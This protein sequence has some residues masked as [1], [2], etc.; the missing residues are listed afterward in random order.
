[1]ACA[2]RENRCRVLRADDAEHDEGNRLRCQGFHLKPIQTPRLFQMKPISRFG[3]LSIFVSMSLPLTAETWIGGTSVNWSDAANWNPGLPASGANIIISD[4][5]AN[6]GITLN[7]ASHTVGSVTFGTTGTRL[8]AFPIVTTAATT[9]TISGGVIANAQFT[10]ISPRFRG[11]VLLSANQNWQV[12]GDP[13]SHAADSGVAFNEIGA[14][15]GGTLGLNGTLTKTGPG[16]LTIGPVITTGPGDIIVNE[17]SLKLNAGGSL[18]HIMENAEGGGKVVV[19]NS[20][21]LIISKNSGTF[22]ISRPFQFNGT[23]N[24][25][26]GSG[27]NGLTGTFDVGSDIAWNGTHTITNNQNANNANNVNY[28]FTGAM[29]GTGSITKSG[30]SQLIL[31]GATANTISGPV[32]VTGGE[33]NLDKTDVQAVGGNI[34]LTGGNLRINKPNQ[35]AD[36]ASIT[37]NG[38]LINFTADRLETIAALTINSAATS[39]L[40]GLTV[41]GATTITAGTQELNSGQKFTTNSLSISGNGG[42][43]PVGNATA[44]ITSDINVGAGGLTLNTAR[45]V[46]GNAGNA[47]SIN[48][49]LAGNVSASGNNVFSVANYNGGR[50]IDLQAGSR[51]FA[52]NDGT[53]DIRY[54]IR[55]G[56]FVKTGPGKL[57]LTRTGSTADFSF[58]QGPVKITGATTAA[59]ATLS[60]GSLEMDLSETT[61][62]LTTSGNFTSTGGTIEVTAIG[63]AVITQ[64]VKELIR[65]NGTL[66]GQPPVNFEPAFATSRMN[67]SVSYGTG[68]NSSISVNVTTAP[69][70]LF[71]IG[72]AADGLWDLN[73]TANFNGEKFYSLDSVVFDDFAANP[74]I[75]LNSVLLPK[76]VSFNNG[77]VP[78]LT[79]SGTGGIGGTTSVT[80]RGTGTTVLETVNS[81][82]G[83]TEVIGGTLTLKHPTLNDTAPVVIAATGAVLNLDFSG[84]DQV[85][86]L[87]IGTTVLAN[88]V[89]DAVSHP[90]IISGTGSLRVGPPVGG[91]GFASW[92]ASFPFQAGVNDG[93]LN[94]PDGD[95]IS[96]LL[97]YVLG[98]TPIGAGA[99]NTSILPTKT[100][101][102]T[103]LVLTF[104]RSDLSEA[105][106]TLKVQWSAD[107]ITWNDF[108]TVGAS[109]SLPAVA[110]TEDSPSA[111]VDTVVVTI[112]RS[113]SPSGKLFVRLVAAK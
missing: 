53:L 48:L 96:N 17:G 38:G 20:A 26:T 111:N 76:D 33:L 83:K 92:A 50:V 66:T 113:T 89:Y 85:G 25:V 18:P 28:R 64:G 57:I 95:G 112:P 67:P 107:M 106:T 14:G 47:S 52:V 54:T 81:Y 93:A 60:G 51:T 101:T 90:G 2:L 105:D 3:F 104:Q 79:V 94:D 19:N 68:T 8:A 46:F 15:V 100:L 6:T 29:S 12:G 55:N 11:N 77:T 35:I 65:Y 42:I 110:I 109:S 63:P 9:L 72:S 4:S 82:T 75:K 1:M 39:S 86:S 23:S 74:N 22:S 58:T 45:L 21:T 27:T 73:N 49:N 56:T 16:Q 13:G 59:T 5:A 87:T 43:R 37:V 103:D 70:T 36:T 10:G 31:S 97:E 102:A 62:K 24:L 108:A 34:L 40:S 78:T 88:G 80:K 69:A 84:T 71:W 41:T 99:S 98:G 61:S 44:P 30:A 91:T 7:D 32:T